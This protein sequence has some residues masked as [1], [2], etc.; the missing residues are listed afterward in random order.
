VPPYA[1]TASYIRRVKR[2][3]EKSKAGVLLEAAPQP[4]VKKA[5]P[6]PAAGSS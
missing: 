2:G 3:Y 5:T 6:S 4:S 1:E